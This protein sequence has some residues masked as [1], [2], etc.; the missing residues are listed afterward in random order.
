MA[1]KSLSALTT[2][3][4]TAFSPTLQLSTL[5]STLSN[6][7]SSLFSPKTP[8]TNTDTLTGLLDKIALTKTFD[9]SALT[10]SLPQVISSIQNLSS[11]SSGSNSDVL[12]T[13]MSTLQPILQN[14]S[15]KSSSTEMNQLMQSLPT[16]VNSLQALMNS[17]NTQTDLPDNITAAINAMKPL[18]SLLGSAN[19]SSDATQIISTL[20][21]A[22]EYAQPLIQLVGTVSSG[23]IDYGQLAQGATSALMPLLAA[24]NKGDSSIDMAQLSHALPTVVGSVTN[25]V[26]AISSA[27]QGNIPETISSVIKGINPL[28]DLLA[29]SDVMN[30]D[31]AQTVKAVYDVLNSMSTILDVVNNPSL[32][33]LSTD[34]NQVIDSLKPVIALMDS[35]G[36]ATQF[37]DQL[38]IPDLGDLLGN[39]APEK[40]D[41]GSITDQF[42]QLTEN[43]TGQLPNI[44][45]LLENLGSAQGDFDIST[46]IPSIKDALGNILYP[47]MPLN[48]LQADSISPVLNILDIQ[49]QSYI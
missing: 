35:N 2:K 29:N 43:L 13:L 40:I 37:L 48:T 10:Q 5:S 39:L 6:S 25:L 4:S 33:T 24:I 15:G 49:Q 31:Q 38:T 19:T 41:L 22:L 36:E 8:S 18:L 47:V 44:N 32:L 26:T 7:V 30:A 21:Q 28:L 34:L 11:A 42:N 12:N 9:F 17:A 46:I 16:V 14:L 23:Q 20:N 1:I 27:N 45:D 3:L